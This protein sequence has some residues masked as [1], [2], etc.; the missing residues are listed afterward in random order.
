M[1]K[2]CGKCG[3]KLDDTTGL[4]PNCDADKLKEQSDKSEAVDV[5]KSTQETVP[6]SEKPLSR[7][8]AKKKR[9]AD[10]KAKKKEERAQWSTGK[11]VRRFFLQLALIILFLFMVATGIVFG[12]SYFGFI[13]S[14]AII[15]IME[16]LEI[17]YGSNTEKLFEDFANEYR[18][19]SENEDGTYTIEIIA[20]DFAS[21]FQK[22]VESNPTLTLNLETIRGMIERYPDLKKIYEF[23]V[24]SKKKTDVQMA[25]LQQVSYN[26]MVSAIIDTSIT[27]PQKQE[28]V[29]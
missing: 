27:E 16:R 8:E 17:E 4:C 9:K 26:L 5:A 7:K 25:F 2:F 24:A 20:P 18:V 13:Q 14:P 12:L 22:E 19:L 21:I 3:A 1:A 10:K 28:V 23:T 6:A 15:N 29:E 11:K